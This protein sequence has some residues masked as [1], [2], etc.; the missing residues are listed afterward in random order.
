MPPPG[1]RGRGAS[2]VQST[3]PSGADRRTRRPGKTDTP[4]FGTAAVA[5]RA[6]VENSAAAA[7]DALP[8]RNE[9]RLSVCT[10]RE[11]KE[12]RGQWWTRG[13]AAQSFQV[14]PKFAVH[15]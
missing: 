11:G 5:P 3:T 15:Q 2:R 7:N 1:S 4:N 14:T 12:W 10:R 8:A 13:G 9:R 6:R